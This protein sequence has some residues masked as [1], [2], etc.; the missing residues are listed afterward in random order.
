MLVSNLTAS[1]ARDLLVYDSENGVLRWRISRPNAPAVRAGAIAGILMRDGYVRVK[2]DGRPYS[3]HRVVWLILLGEWPV[4]TLDHIN[5]DRNDNRIEN[6]REATQLENAKNK[7]MAANNTSGYKGVTYHKGNNR[8]QAR[9]RVN[10]RLIHLGYHDTAESASTS[11]REAA[12]R[13]FGLF[14][15]GRGAECAP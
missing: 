4:D 5:G 6:L 9:I 7:I 3:A 12:N 1:R 2:I 14:V 10:G 8:W 11:Y 13:Y 15:R